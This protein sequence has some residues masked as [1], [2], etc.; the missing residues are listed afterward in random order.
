[1]GRWVFY[2]LIIKYKRI[3]IYTPSP[4]PPHNVLKL[5]RST[6]RISSCLFEHGDIPTYLWAACCYTIVGV[7]N[8]PYSAKPAQRSS[9]TGPPGYIG[10]TWFQPMQPGGPVRLLRRAGLADFKVRIKLPPQ[11][12]LS[13]RAGSGYSWAY[14]PAPSP[15]NTLLTKKIRWRHAELKGG[16]GGG[17][18]GKIREKHTGA[19]K[20]EKHSRFFHTKG[21]ALCTKCAQNIQKKILSGGKERVQKYCMFSCI[22]VQAT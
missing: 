2:F 5:V 14:L 17:G 3:K 4:P 10:W 21:G 13:R 15:Q 7:L 11:V 1:M 8:E 6:K 18:R 20:K 22:A 9:H 19:G 16:E 12:S